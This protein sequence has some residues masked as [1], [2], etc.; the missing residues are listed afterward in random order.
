MKVLATTVLFAS[1]MAQFNER[2]FN[3]ISRM[4]YELVDTSFSAKEFGKRIQ[5]YG[6]HCFPGFTKEAGGQGAPVNEVDGL[7]KVLA[8]CHK[9][10]AIEF[11][12][13][14]DVNTGKY[15]WEVDGG[16]ISCAKTSNPARR[17]LCQCDAA[18]AMSMATT[19]DDADFNTFYWLAAQNNDPQ[20]DQ[21]ATCAVGTGA[22]GA[23]NADQC[24]NMQP[25]DSDSKSCCKGTTLY[26]HVLNE[27]CADGSVA[28]LGSC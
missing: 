26:N 25:Y 17:A 22:G 6:C 18:F 10:V 13:E 12:G 9:C 24:C 19:W 20:F 11:P 3:A 23:G 5:N 15:N 28:S 14:I 16:S 2:K 8:R 4:S 21:E 7:C 27:C 1:S